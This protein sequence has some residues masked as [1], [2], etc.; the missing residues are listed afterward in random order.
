[1]FDIWIP[2]GGVSIVSHN[3][4]LISNEDLPDLIVIQAMVFKFQVD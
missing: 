3:F 1:M 2:L 4:K